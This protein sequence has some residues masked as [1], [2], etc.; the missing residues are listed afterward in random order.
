MSP[1]ATNGRAEV[2]RMLSSKTKNRRYWVM[3]RP[4]SRAVLLIFM[5]LNLTGCI[6]TSWQSVDTVAPAEVNQELEVPLWERLLMDPGE[7]SRVRVLT[8]DSIWVELENAEVF[9]DEIVGDKSEG[10]WFWKKWSEVVIPMETIQDLQVLRPDP[11]STLVFGVGGL[12][13]ISIIMST[14]YSSAP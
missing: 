12:V 8:S 10:S 2:A 13:G 7:E 4:R 14:F 11:R 9:V 3:T 1:V 5:M 6:L